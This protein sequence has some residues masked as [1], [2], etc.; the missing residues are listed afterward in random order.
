[1]RRDLLYPIFLECVKYTEDGFWRQ[2]FEDLAYTQ[3]PYGS[4]FNKGFFCCS[5]KGKEFSYKIEGDDAEKIFNDVY[6]LLSNKL[7]ITSSNDRVKKIQDF[8]KIRNEFQEI[9]N[10][11][12]SS[13]KKKTTRDFIIENFIVEMKKTYKLS[14]KESRRLNSI[15][16]I[17]LLFKTILPKDIEYENGRISSIANIFFSEGQVTFDHSNLHSDNMVYNIV[18]QEKGTLIELWRKYVKDNFSTMPKMAEN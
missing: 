8:E 14:D 13:I 4:Y 3:C 6:S 16:S 7:G 15:V 10:S 12:W 2:V 18:F 17:G 5:Y 1:M 11:K 9:R